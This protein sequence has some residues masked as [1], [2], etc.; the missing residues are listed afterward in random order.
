M[1]SID[2]LGL[3]AF[4]AIAKCGSFQR[5]ASELHISQTAVSHRL[6]KLE[7][8]LD[9]RLVARTSRAVTLTGAGRELL[10]K[11][12][13]AVQEL[14]LALASAHK[15]GSAS[16]RTIAVACLPTI[17]ASQLAPIVTAFLE[18][19]PG[20]DVRVHDVS[21]GE[22]EELV[23]AGVVE[24]GVTVELPR[25]AGLLAVTVVDEPFVVACP[26][27]HPL[28]T[29]QVVSLEDLGSLPMIRI[30]LPAGNSATI[31][32]ALARCEPRLLW[33]YEVQR[34]ALAL[35]L[36]RAG[37]GLTIVPALAAVPDASLVVRPLV[38]PRIVRTLRLLMREGAELGDEAGSLRALFDAHL[39]SAVDRCTSRS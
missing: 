6:R 5:A 12:R 4:L 26:A 17:A 20:F 7:Q 23:L 39:T 3:Q 8:L 30:G 10:P 11:A 25:S 22:I 31:D 16:G 38:R 18:I 1:S 29:A 37:L 15:H 14:Q 33:R 32:E 28:A 9:T 19:A 36:V 2:F 13:S 21:I 34:T 27:R 35:A 24:F